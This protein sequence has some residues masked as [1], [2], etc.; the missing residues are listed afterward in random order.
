MLRRHM[1]F[2]AVLV[3]VVLALTGFSSGKGSGKGKSKG[4]SSSGGGGCS[5]SK[6]SNGGYAGAGSG[7]HYDDDDDYG[8]GSSSGSTADPYATSTTSGTVQARIVTC[9]RKASGKRKAVTYAT[10]RVD[11]PSGTTG[12]Y[13]ID[14]DFK[15]ASGTVVD[16]ADTEVTLE[17]G[18]SRTLRVTMDSPKQVSRVRTCEARATARS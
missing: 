1:K 11:T 6:K 4:S 17:S 18:E 10:V 13:E 5:S 9:V 7:S 3:V 15:D 8:S 16:N 12:L 2:A 14:V